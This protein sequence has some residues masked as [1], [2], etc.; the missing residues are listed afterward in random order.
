MQLQQLQLTLQEPDDAAQPLQ[1]GHLMALTSLSLQGNFES[2]APQDELP[3]GLKVLHVAGCARCMQ[4]L[5]GLTQLTEL[6][7]VASRTAAAQLQQLANALTALQHVELG[8]KSA[9]TANAAAA[10]WPALPMRA[11]DVSTHFGLAAV[12]FEGIGQL[13]EL[14]RFVI[15]SMPLSPH[16]VTPSQLAGHLR[17][18]TALRELQMV[19]FDFQRQQQLSQQDLQELQ[20]RQQLYAQ[21]NVHLRQLH[22]QR[23]QQQLRGDCALE[24]EREQQAA[25]NSGHHWTS[26][27]AEAAETD[28]TALDMMDSPEEPSTL[29]AAAFVIRQD[30]LEL[31]QAIAGLA[32][33]RSLELK[34]IRLGNAAAQLA[35]ATQL[36]HVRLEDCGVLHPASRQVVLGLNTLG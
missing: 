11:L 35:A 26:T 12:T 15:R 13:T 8:Y 7:V 17:Q 32:N 3:A 29:N 2:F 14:T 6:C 34:R 33:L 4:P 22:L 5:L 27:T 24:D 9:A 20:Q 23:Q 18:L 30:M 19:R 25:Q 10:A 16:K 28:Q 21:L 31:V 1:L 36:T